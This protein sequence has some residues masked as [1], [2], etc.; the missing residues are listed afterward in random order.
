M[1]RNTA[2]NERIKEERRERILLG[3]L[4]LFAANGLGATKISDIASRTKMSNGLV[5]HYF[6]AKEDIF[7]ELIRIAFEK[8]TAACYA[9]Q[10]MP[11]SPHG[12]LRYAIDELVRT[13]RTRPTASLYHL[14]IAQATASDNIPQAAQKILAENRRIPYLVI[15]EIILLGQQQDT[16]L[17]GN[18]EDLAFFFWV[19]I[20]GI[21]L[22][23]A[24]YG[25]GAQSPDLTPLYRLFFKE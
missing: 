17:H 23:Q 14:L 18:P 21:A 3:A 15:A 4:E 25:T 2:D 12:K 11:L 13:I 6:N 19:N 10:A 7:T 9:L 1:A 16:I 20:N 24:M 22:H 5:Y 8:M